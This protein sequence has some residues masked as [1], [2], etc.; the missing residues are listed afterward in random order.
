MANINKSVVIQL[1]DCGIIDIVTEFDE[2]YISEYTGCPT[3]GY[4][5]Y[6]E[7]IQ[8]AKVITTGETRV[9]TFFQENYWTS[10]VESVAEEGG[11]FKLFLV[12][13][14]DLIQLLLNK[15]T[16]EMLKDKTLE[17]F[18]EWLKDELEVV[19][20]QRWAKERYSL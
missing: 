16:L 11:N 9:V 14:A 10:V 15:D 20:T 3:C 19:A 17:Q 8:T 5:E 4:D 2:Q 13:E 1:A 12:T 18:C 6:Y 7:N